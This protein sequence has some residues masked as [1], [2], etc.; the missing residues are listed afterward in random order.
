MAYLPVNLANILASFGTIIILT[1]LLEP[2]DWGIY[3]LAIITMHAVHML[4]FTWL[5]AAMARFQARAEQENDVNTHLKTIYIMALIMAIIGF[6]IGIGAITILPLD[7]DLRSVLFIAF[8]STCLML[9]FNLS[10]EAHK[11]AHRIKRYSL[12]YSA[13]TLI[14][15]TIGVILILYTPLK[16]EAPFIGITIS[17]MTIGLIDFLFITKLMQGGAYEAAKVKTYL[18]YGVP[19][20]IALV[21][22]YALNAADSYMIAY[23]LDIESQGKYIAGYNLSNRTI[24]LI[25]TWVAMAVTPMAITAFEKESSEVS[26]KIMK[27][28][29]VTL[30]WLTM[31]AATGIALVADNAGF[32]LG[33]GIRD[34]AITVIPLIAFA[35]LISGFMTYYVHHAYMLSGKT[36][37]FLWVL[38]PPVIVNIGLNFNF[39]PQYGLMGAVWATVISYSFACIS[40]IILG[41]RYY[42]LPLPFIAAAQIGLAC[43]FMAFCVH[44]I[45]LPLAPY[46]PDPVLFFAKASL[47]AFSYILICFT[48]NIANCREF[49]KSLSAKVLTA[50]VKAKA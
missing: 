39:I 14:S 49:T 22:S 46:F 4:L 1:R 2:K 10:M 3:A 25:F 18:H 24:T 31:P 38:V 19:I 41:R 20:S 32:I 44:M 7:K 8:G 11:A 43:L 45:F 13:H 16:G 21:L 42:P 5:E 27:D 12:N 23:F 30:L 48:G 37:A 36:Q 28:F 29:A 9:F 17:L 40:A 50:R 26:Q 33:E 35:G 15:F 6:I 47:G 34:E